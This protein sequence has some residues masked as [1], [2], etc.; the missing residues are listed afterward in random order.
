MVMTFISVSLPICKQNRDFSIN[1][2]LSLDKD[3]YHQWLVQRE[4]SQ[5]IGY[6]QV[7]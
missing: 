1:V 2:Q 7:K 4:W 6:L 3:K 5:C